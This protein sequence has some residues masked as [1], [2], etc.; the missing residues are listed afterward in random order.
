MGLPRSWWVSL[1]LDGSP[2]VL[3]GIQLVYS[4]KNIMWVHR[5]VKN[6]GP[7]GVRAVRMRTPGVHKLVGP[8]YLQ[9]LIRVLLKT[10]P[11]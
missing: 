3:T 4:L 2:S 1:D 7:L 11:I 10:K 6:W 8:D 5:L 9:L